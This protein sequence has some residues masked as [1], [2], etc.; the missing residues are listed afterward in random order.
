MNGIG[1]FI[2]GKRVAGDS[3]RRGDVFDPA[4]VFSSL[5]P[6]GRYAFGNPPRLAQWNLARFGEPLL[7]LLGE[8]TDAA[9]AAA[10]E[11]L[12]AFPHTY[13]AH[14]GAGM[15]RKLG[16]EDV[17]PG[18]DDLVDDLLGLLHAHHVDFTSSFR[19]LADLLRGDDAA[20]R[21]LFSSSPLFDA[22]ARRWTARVDHQARDRSATADA[23]DAVNPRYV[24][25][26]HR[27]EEALDAATAGDLE[28]L[29][30]LV[31]VLRRPFDERSGL[32]EYAGPA[33]E[34][35]GPY[36]TFCGT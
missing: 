21:E 17:R 27:V 8:D 19:S 30:R 23:M 22:W 25:R 11:R 31:D 5:D 2:D 7:P 33:P 28:P 16:L 3:E 10:T 32:E 6:R 29:Q 26:N 12:D 14:L 20:V 18:D 1:H 35:F 24:P 36:R 13:D 34:D 15:R 4:T 9:V